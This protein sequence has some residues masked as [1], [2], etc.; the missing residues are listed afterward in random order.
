[1][2]RYVFFDIECADGGKGSICS[3][4]YVITDE[5]FHEL[6]SQDI[7]INPESRFYLVGRSRRPDIILSYSEAEFRKAPKFPAFYQK[8]KALL[9]AEDQI[10]MGH[11]VQ[12]DVNFLCK[13]CARYGL[14][15]L[16]F[17]FADSQSLYSSAYQSEGQ[18][19]LDRA[20][21]MFSIP[22]PQDVHN[23][24]ADARATMLLVKKICES[25]KLSLNNYIKDHRVWGETEASKIFC[26]YIHPNRT[27]FAA[28]LDKA[29]P[30]NKREQVLAGKT[31]CVSMALEQPREAQIYHL[32]QM[33]IDAGGNYTRVASECD[34]FVT[35]S[36]EPARIC[37]RTKTAR[38]AKRGGKR[39]EMISLDELLKRLGVTKA[40]YQA[41]P[42]PDIHW[43]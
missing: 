26:S 24:E 18:L 36:A 21:E 23:S 38:D 10:V 27:M 31:V 15:P 43:L 6:E 32:A 7:V 2:M 19:G 34:I 30:K 17:R 40:E 25:K 14:P 16:K 28:F 35:G 42:M 29:E 20:C 12:D 39:I 11:S 5:H 8:I 33:I 13:D 1:M 22:K 9:E 3:F 4:G 37:K 41:L